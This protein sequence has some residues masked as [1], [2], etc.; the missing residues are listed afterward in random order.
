MGRIGTVKRTLHDVI[1]DQISN[2]F[3]WEGVRSLSSRIEA[4]EGVTQTTVYS[5]INENEITQMASDTG[6]DYSVDPPVQMVFPDISARVDNFDNFGVTLLSRVDA[7]IADAIT[8]RADI[9]EALDSLTARVS[10]LED[11]VNANL[12]A[13]TRIQ[14]KIA[15]GGVTSIDVG[16]TVS[17]ITPANVYHKCRVFRNGLMLFEGS[18]YDYTVSGSTI[19]VAANEDDRIIIEYQS[20]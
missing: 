6:Y 4:I 20:V 12:G 16:V 14:Y 10:A 11:Q 8:G 3:K 13:V 15:A 19:Y 18:G 17:T 7:R 9:D 1:G 5:I 2:E